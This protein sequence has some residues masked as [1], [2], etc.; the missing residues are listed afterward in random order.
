MDLNLGFLLISVVKIAALLGLDVRPPLG[1]GPRLA[2]GE[3]R[4]RRGR[5][6][7]H[8]ARHFRRRSAAWPIF[9]DFDSGLLF[10]A[11]R[12]PWSRWV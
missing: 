1:P 9:S 12:W 8:P 10:Q 6:R 11:A 7:R 4:D 2:P 5:V 3:M